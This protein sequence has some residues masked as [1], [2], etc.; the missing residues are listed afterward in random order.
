MFNKPKSLEAI[1]ASFN[2]TVVELEVLQDLNKKSI[3]NKESLIS[4]LEASARALRDENDRAAR[5]QVKVRN[6]L[7]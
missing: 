1:L 5:V 4:D 3:E 6:L 2:K 7:S